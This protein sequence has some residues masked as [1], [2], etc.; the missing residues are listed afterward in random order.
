MDVVPDGNAPLIPAGMASVQ[1]IVAPAVVDV[2][3]TAAEVLVLHIVCS[4]EENCTWG[5]GLTV[6]VKLCGLPLQL[7][8]A[9]VTDGVTVIVPVTGALPVFTALKELISPVPP[10]LNPMDILL[11]VQ[12]YTVPATA[13]PVKLTAAVAA[14]LQTICTAG[15]VT[16]GVGF[17]VMIKV[18]TGPGQAVPAFV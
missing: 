14:P 1:P 13:E 18:L 4:I 7:I 6:I 8:P 2:S 16:E 5:A 15:A 12:L 3:E 17:T 10:A 11:F 9:L